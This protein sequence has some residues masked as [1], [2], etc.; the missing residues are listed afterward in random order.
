M[1]LWRG[2]PIIYLVLTN[3][4]WK[5]EVSPCSTVFIPKSHEV[6]GCPTALGAL[7]LSAAFTQ[8]NGAS[9]HGR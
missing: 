5:E 1:C 8:P 3:K 4:F 9:L 6:S 2:G 7:Q